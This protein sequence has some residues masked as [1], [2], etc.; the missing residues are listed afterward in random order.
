[1]AKVDLV[2]V[3]AGGGHRASAEAL[4][5]ALNEQ[6]SWQ[7]RLV[8]LQALLRPLDQFGR[9]T[10]LYVEDAYNLMLRKNWTWGARYGIPLLHFVIRC[11]HQDQVLLLSKYWTDDPPDLVVSMVSHFNRALREGILRAAPFVPFAVVITD[12]ADVPPHFWIEPQDQF[13]ICGS[14]RAVKQARALNIPSDRIYQT[15]G[16]ILHPCFYVPVAM[17]RAAERERLG[18][19]PSTLT[20]IVTFGGQ[21][22]SAMIEIV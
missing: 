1:M 19:D 4:C 6:R 5:A 8:N 14:T 16:M 3:D 10:G 12:F 22:S 11:F 21:G 13:V 18:L 20:A 9:L 2:Y 7:V 17:D 15:S